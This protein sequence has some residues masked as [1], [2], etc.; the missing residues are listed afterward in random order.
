MTAVSGNMARQI[1]E[2]S[3]PGHVFICRPR[4]CAITGNYTLLEGFDTEYW[5]AQGCLATQIM[6]NKIPRHDGLWGIP[7]FPAVCRD[8][9]DPG[10]F[11]EQDKYRRGVRLVFT[12]GTT[13]QD[14][15]FISK[16]LD[17]K[18]IPTELFG[19]SVAGNWRDFFFRVLFLF[20]SF[21][22]LGASM[23]PCVFS[24][25]DRMVHCTINSLSN[26]AQIS[27]LVYS[28]VSSRI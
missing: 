20:D 5:D 25:W 7:Y 11:V 2:S 9:L 13:W 4:V 23:M 18:Q 19:G 17:L 21:G 26:Q 8:E 12:E 1:R 24:A 28:G 22:S 3:S 16:L 6:Q 27:G 10:G 14:G 15:N